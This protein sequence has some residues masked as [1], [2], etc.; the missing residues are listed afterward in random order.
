MKRLLQGALFVLLC[1]VVLGSTASATAVLELYDNATSVYITITDTGIVTCSAP[2]SSECL[3]AV[4]NESHA[5]GAIS[6]GLGTHFDD[7]TITSSSGSSNSP[8]CNGVPYGPGCAN[9]HN[10][11]SVSPG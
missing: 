8:G 9:T 5:T 4:I 3:T 7:F 10:A 2:L 11:N 6:L 1:A